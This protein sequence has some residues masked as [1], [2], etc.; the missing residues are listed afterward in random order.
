MNRHSNKTG[1]NITAALLLLPVLGWITNANAVLQPGFDQALL[2]DVGDTFGRNRAYGVGVA[3]FNGDGIDDIV[4]GDTAGDVHY[5]QGVGD[6]TFTGGA[7]VINAGFH[8]AY[9]L[10]TGDF[11]NDG[12]Q[13]VVGRGHGG[14]SE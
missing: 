4:S 10:A 8:D 2:G 13:D 3:D 1:V 12:K 14:S 11:N 7:A 9:G 6:G 5:F